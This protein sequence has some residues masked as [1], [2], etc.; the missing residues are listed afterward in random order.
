MQSKVSIQRLEKLR[1]IDGP[2]LSN[3]IESFKVRDRSQGFMSMDI[4]CLFPEL[5]T[6]VGYA[7]TAT[8]DSTTPGDPPARSGWFKL[9]EA[10]D[11]APKPAI[12]VIKDVTSTPRL[13]CHFGDVMANIASRLGAEGVITDG[14]VRDTAEVRRLGFRFFAPGVVVSHGNFQILDVEVPVEV[15]G[16]PVDPGD[17]LHASE[18]G[19]LKLPHE[20]V[21]QLPAEVERVRAREKHI[22]AYANGADFS[23]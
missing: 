19:V 8:A 12:L 9:W 7:L 14:G 17:L 15:G 11:A 10:L 18:D 5:G 3:A 22:M 1:A 4:R 21:D 20:L 2:T 16:L 13:S 6:M 23:V